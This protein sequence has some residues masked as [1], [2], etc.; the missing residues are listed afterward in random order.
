[1]KKTLNKPLGISSTTID[2]PVSILL[3]MAEYDKKA[4]SYGK[5]IPINR[6]EK[7]QLNWSI[8]SN[9]DELND[10]HKRAKGVTKIGDR[11]SIVDY[12]RF[13]SLDDADNEKKEM[14]KTKN[15]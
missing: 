13:Y 7:L 9:L 15:R 5:G 14:Q 11:R 4:S 3:V 6:G 1:M 10:H 2:G 8:F 12:I